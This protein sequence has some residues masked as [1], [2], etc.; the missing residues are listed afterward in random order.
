MHLP[1][2]ESINTGKLKAVFNNTSASYKFY[3]FLSILDCIEQ[4]KT[5][6]SKH[7][8]FARMIANS[9]YTVN[10]FKISFGIQDKLHD[11]I[12]FL[13]KHENIGLNETKERIVERLIKANSIQKLIR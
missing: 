2:S 13:N 8:L 11:T 1:E 12:C 10:Y 6:I 7:E 5:T 4:Q 3:W 9:Y